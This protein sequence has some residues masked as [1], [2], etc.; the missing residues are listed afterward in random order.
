M[1]S[2]ARPPA[3][4]VQVRPTACDRKLLRRFA[5]REARVIVEVD[6]ATNATPAEVARDSTRDRALEALGY[7]IVRVHNIDIDQ[8]IEGVLDHL[9]SELENSG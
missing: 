2:P 1:V 7:R 5:C 3:R 8:N 9:L 6:G 4:R